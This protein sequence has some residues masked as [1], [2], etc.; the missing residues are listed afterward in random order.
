[1]R[2]GT[3]KAVC[4]ILP[5]G[6]SVPAV[7]RQGW[8][9]FNVASTPGLVCRGPGHWHLQLSLTVVVGTS[10]IFEIVAEWKGLWRADLS[11]LDMFLKMPTMG[12]DF[13]DCWPSYGR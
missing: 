3:C 4:V 1:M 2:C 12:T 11:I 8:L 5:G 9:V 10:M 13:E 7:M 6:H